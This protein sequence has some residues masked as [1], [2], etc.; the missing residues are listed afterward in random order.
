MRPKAIIFDFDGVL[1]DSLQAHL[2]AWAS[3]IKEVFGVDAED[4]R[5]LSGH[6]S[7]TI[8]HILSKRYGDPSC[9]SLLANTKERLLCSNSDVQ[10]F[11]KVREVFESLAASNIPYGIA[12]NSRRP[13]IEHTLGNAEIFA[14]VLVTATEVTRLKPHPDIFWECSNRLDIEPS[15]RQHSW[16]FEDSTHGIKA[17]LAAGM[18]PLGVATAVQPDQL[19]SAGAVATCQSIADAYA[20]GWF[21]DPFQ[22]A[23]MV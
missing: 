13:F 8:A 15:W 2:I 4:L 14:P 17:A 3:A 21:G 5:E 11:P 16:V 10:L 18:I 7:R 23:G 9:A 6:S 1:A 19:I 12:S 20:M 22:I